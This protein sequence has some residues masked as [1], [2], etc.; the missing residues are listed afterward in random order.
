M[1]LEKAAKRISSSKVFNPK[2][3]LSL[4]DKLNS[5][6]TQ[7]A[8]ISFRKK[9]LESQMRSNYVNEFNRL[10]GHLYANPNL[11]TNDHIKTI[12]NKLQ[13]LAKKSLYGKESLYKDNVDDY[14]V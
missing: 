10:K 8:S 14:K 9:L 11:P 4:Q 12:L 5:R 7:E 13:D 3:E 2:H 6:N 1:D